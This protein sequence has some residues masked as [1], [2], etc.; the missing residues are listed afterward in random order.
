MRNFLFSL[1]LLLA[2]GTPMAAQDAIEAPPQCLFKTYDSYHVPYRIPAIATTKKGH[3]IAV[4]DRRY[5]GFDIGFGRIDMVART[6]K[7]NGRTWSPDTV[8]QRGTGVK[9]S[10]DC[11]YGDAALVADRTSNRVL[12]M[13][14]TGSTPYINGTREKPNRVARWYSPNGGKSWTKAEDVTEQIYA[15]LP[16][17]RTLFIGSGRIMQSRVV[18]ADRYYR[19]Y[20]SV[21]T[22]T[23]MSDKDVACNYVL[24]SDDFGASWAV[25]GGSTLDGHDSPCVGGD[26]PKTEE[27]PN[28]DVI[29]SSRTWRGRYFNVFHFND[30]RHNT[31]EGSWGK[32]STSFEVPGGISVGNNSTNGEIMLVDAIETATGRKAKL[33]LQSLPFGEGRSDVGFWYKEIV[34]NGIYSPRAFAH[35]WTRGLRVSHTTSAYST[36]SLQKDGRIAFFW[37]EN[38]TENGYDLYYQPISISEITGGKFV[39]P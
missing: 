15:L 11:G 27:L 7:N 24:Y 35:N 6:S 22:R 25:L 8:I 32:C 10:D 26:E 17:T 37:E 30:V 28:G 33:M 14:V 9:G 19:L 5:C 21:L 12:C 3:L 29:L 16:H 38:S 39:A 20:C 36:M 31:V 2:A 13:S 4:G 1:A 34:P 18:K 23:Q